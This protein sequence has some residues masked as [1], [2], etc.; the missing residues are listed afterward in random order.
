MGRMCQDIKILGEK[1][2]RS[3]ALNREECQIILRKARAHKGLMMMIVVGCRNRKKM[4][5]SFE[6]FFY[7]S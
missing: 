2:W 6:T 5:E 3:V 4:L 7:L 1:N